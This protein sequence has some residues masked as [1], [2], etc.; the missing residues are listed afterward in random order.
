MIYKAFALSTLTALASVLPASVALAN[1]DTSLFI[2]GETTIGGITAKV[3]QGINP[4]DSHGSLGAFSEFYGDN[5]ATV[6]F[7]AAGTHI[8][9]NRYTFGHDFITYTF[10]KSPGTAPG[11]GTGLHNGRWAPTGANG[12]R[13]QSTYLAVFKGN[14]VTIDV[15]EEL[16]YFGINWGALSRGND[17]AFLKDGKEIG[18]FTYRDINPIASV[19]AAHQKNQGNGYV[20]FYTD[21]VGSSFNQI[22]ISQTDHRGGGFE[23]DNHSFRLGSDVFDFDQ[24]L[25][26]SQT[27]PEPTTMLAFATIGALMLRRKLNRA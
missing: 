2:F 19:K 8:G 11:Q 3:T 13:N 24:T 10:E 21:S 26:E 23:T 1:D 27:V 15:A 12:E 5:T 14:S 22:V 7:N 6:D 17:F 18:T 9:E 4:G 16:N 25:A 20:H